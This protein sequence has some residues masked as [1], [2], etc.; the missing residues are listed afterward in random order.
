MLIA[1]HSAFS[2]NVLYLH[3]QPSKMESPL[4]RPTEQST[5]RFLELS[6]NLRLRIYELLF[7]SSKRR[8]IVGLDPNSIACKYP[9][10]NL[11]K[12]PIPVALLQTCKLVNTEAAPILYASID[13]LVSI[14]PMVSSGHSMHNLDDF[15]ALTKLKKITLIPWSW[16]PWRSEL[17]VKATKDLLEALDYCHHMRELT[18][19]FNE[20][21][22]FH[23]RNRL[24][25]LLGVLQQIQCA[26][27]VCFDT[28]YCHS[29]EYRGKGYMN[30]MEALNA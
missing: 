6:P 22:Y 21:W 16:E 7:S 4:E 12:N 17:L 26:G 28:S 14:Q 27:S 5:S 15:A 23:R 2:T 29:F 8:F 11:D 13:V 30:L 20:A 3:C 18:I 9:L 25:E 1:S 19:R 10:P 24:D